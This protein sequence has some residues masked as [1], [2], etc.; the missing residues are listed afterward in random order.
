[1]EGQDIQCLHDLLCHLGRMEVLFALYVH[2]YG[3]YRKIFQVRVWFNGLNLILERTWVF[4]I[5]VIS[6]LCFVDSEFDAEN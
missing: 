5:G 1:M 6:F 4:F 3:Q 2:K